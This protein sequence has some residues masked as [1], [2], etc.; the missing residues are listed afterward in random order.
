MLHVVMATAAMLTAV[1]MHRLHRF[2]PVTRRRRVSSHAAGRRTFL[3][4]FLH[5]TQLLRLLLVLVPVLSLLRHRHVMLMVLG[6][7]TLAPA[8]RRM[9]D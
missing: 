9:L 5:W 6:N 3:H 7:G 2:L 1:M 4:P 8:L